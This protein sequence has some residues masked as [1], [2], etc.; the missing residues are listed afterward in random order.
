MKDRYNDV[1]DLPSSAERLT[2]FDFLI[3][4][5]LISFLDGSGNPEAGRSGV[6]SHDD[7]VRAR[8]AG[9]I[10]DNDKDHVNKDGDPDEE[11]ET[12]CQLLQELITT[13]HD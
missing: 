10:I 3:E 13:W 8:T 5:R 4:G 12:S 7:L 11:L 1:L 2:N 6:L 9:A